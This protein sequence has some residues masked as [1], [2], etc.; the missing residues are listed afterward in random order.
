ML[1]NTLVTCMYIRA[2]D[3]LLPTHEFS[4]KADYIS[5]PSL[6][7]KAVLYVV[8][9]LL[10]QENTEYPLESPFQSG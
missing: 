1:D 9:A 7:I 4:C 5:C 6:L 10:K 3:L 2:L 8:A